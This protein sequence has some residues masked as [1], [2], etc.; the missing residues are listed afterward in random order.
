M[1]AGISD[2]AASSG[3]W[4]QAVPPTARTAVT[5]ALPSVLAPVSRIAS[6]RSPSTS[7]ADSNKR[8]IAGRENNTGASI[9]NARLS[10]FSTSR[11]WS[12][13]ATVAVP[14]SSGC[15]SSASRTGSAQRAFSSSAIW[16][17]RS[18]G[19]CST[20]ST[21]IGQSAARPDNNAC[22]AIT[23]PADAPT[24]IASNCCAFGMRLMR[25]SATAAVRVRTLRT[26]AHVRRTTATP[27]CP[28]RESR[29]APTHRRTTPSHDPASCG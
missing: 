17:G 15:L 29:D 4:I 26:P 20:T 2:A 14:A 23:P 3:R 13:G 22:K 27:C 11:C 10:R 21:G 24:T 8:S 9:D 5:P 6:R 28:A 16:L 25:P 12:G 18:R 7:A 19:R 1:E